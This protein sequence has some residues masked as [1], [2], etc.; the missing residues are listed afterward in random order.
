VQG[1]AADLMKMAMNKVYQEMSQ[2]YST[3]EVKVTLQVHDELVLEVKEALVDEVMAKV[4]KTME[5]VVTLRVP[6][7][8]EIG[9]GKRWGEIK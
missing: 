5:E 8:V 6:V 1:T 7:K 3:D 2:K 9:A 4:K